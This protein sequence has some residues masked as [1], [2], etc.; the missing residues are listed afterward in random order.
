MKSKSFKQTFEGTQR[1]PL[2]TYP[3]SD[4]N[5][6][7]FAELIQNVESLS[8]IVSVHQ[9]ISQSNATAHLHSHS[10]YELICGLN[11]DV[12]YLVGADRYQQQKGDLIWI[13]PGI[14]HKPILP[15]SLE[16]SYHWD[17]LRFSPEFVEALIEIAPDW[18][19]GEQQNYKLI[20]T[21]GTRWRFLPA[22]LRSTAEEFEKKE[23]GWDLI[24]MGNALTILA[25]LRRAVIDETAKIQKVEKPELLDMALGYIEENLVGKITLSGIAQNFYVSESTIS[26]LFQQKLG[27][28]F[29]RYVMQRRL[30]TAENLI[31]K[32][33]SME[34]I[35]E[36]VGFTD[37]SSFYRAF[38]KEYG[39]SP[40]QYRRLQGK[41]KVMDLKV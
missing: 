29:Y 24:V 10:Y 1:P 37:Y 30:N 11:N 8:W 19:K 21:A 7:E 17:V 36:Q 15:K 28:S 4:L 34:W 32:G 6:I 9:E 18:Y 39:M 22:L 2:T 27:I 33:K 23:F 12:E 31:L 20:R 3:N 14:S 5:H 26:H 13:E 41:P 25:H 38:K 16:E 40:S 35:S